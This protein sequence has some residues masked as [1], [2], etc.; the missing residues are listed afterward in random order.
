MGQ[1]SE[2]NSARNRKGRNVEEKPRRRQR[3]FSSMDDD[4]EQEAAH[5]GEGYTLD[6]M[7]PSAKSN[8]R[9]HLPA[10]PKKPPHDGQ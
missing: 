10:W 3:L 2:N 1:C 8:P 4:E 7:N 5:G 9:A 6:D